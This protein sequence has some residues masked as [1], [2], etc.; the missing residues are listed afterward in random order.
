MR[1]LSRSRILAAAFVAVAAGGCSDARPPDSVSSLTPTAPV[2]TPAAVDAAFV[3]RADAVCQPYDA[4]NAA[5]PFPFTDFDPFK[6]D[7]ARL[8][9]VGEFFDRN[10]NNHTLVTELS[11][12]GEPATGGASWHTLL[13][14]VR[15]ST[16]LAQGQIAAAK[17]ADVHGFT[18]NVAQTQN[19]RLTLLQAWAGA[20]FGPKDSCYPD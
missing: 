6:P 17:A 14:E 13:D 10:P 12:L 2:T 1:H 20:G 7:A 19:E 4:Y 5:N 8:P 3:A 11:A 15:T 16:A 18:T 9:A